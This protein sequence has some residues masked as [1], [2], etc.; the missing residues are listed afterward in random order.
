MQGRQCPTVL[1]R[2]PVRVPQQPLC[3]LARQGSLVGSQPHPLRGRLRDSELERA[4]LRPR[5]RGPLALSGR[6]FHASAASR[7]DLGVLA[8]CRDCSNSSMKQW[9][10]PPQRPPAICAYTPHALA[11]SA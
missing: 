5:S 9:R 7:R 11:E 10:G 1:A 2:L 8:S 3:D 4:Q 6:T